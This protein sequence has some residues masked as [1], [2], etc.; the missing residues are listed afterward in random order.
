VVAAATTADDAGRLDAI[1]AE[2]RRRMMLTGVLQGSEE[3]RAEEMARCA[4]DP[5]YWM[6]NWAWTYDP[7][8]MDPWPRSLPFVLWPK[9]EELIR[10]LRARMQGKEQGGIKKARDTGVSWCCVAFGVWLWLFEPETTITYGS[11]K[12]GLVDKLG[13]PDSLVERARMILRM[14]PA[15]MLPTGYK[16]SVHALHMRL[17]N[18]ANSSII[19]GEV[20]DDM[21]RGGR[22]SIY[23][24]DEFAYVPRAQ[25][26][27]SA[28]SDNA[29]TVIWLSTSAGTGTEFWRKEQAG[30]IEFFR[31]FWHHDPRKDEAWAD[32]KKEVDGPATFAREHEGDDASALDNV[33]IPYAWLICAIDLDL[34]P[35]R[36]CAG[37]LDVADEGADENVLM[38]RRGPLVT[39]TETWTGLLPNQSAR[40]AIQTLEDED[41]DWLHYDRVGVGSGVAGELEEAPR[42]FA[43]A[44]VLGGGKPS[45]T[46]YWD[47]PER[48]AQERFVDRNAELWWHLRLRFQATYEQVEGIREHPPERLI[49]IPNDARLI[50]QLTSRLYTSDGDRKIA[51]ESKRAMRK[52]G[53][54]KSPDRADACAYCFAPAPAAAMID[55]VMY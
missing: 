49:S 1:S 45:L 11:R 41:A 47:D 31:I 28:I 29:N 42:P 20:G 27:S 7:R 2:M 50:A 37:G 55:E 5:V 13:D 38:I 3:A 19:K 14:L 39:L 16:E 26:V 52:R 25:A 17:L 18:P 43:Y 15:W 48:S 30:A 32:K 6:A 21:G 8:K 22:S 10:W 46:Y 36:D 33:T 51:V 54:G 9:Q 35:G 23:F 53:V 24:A 34:D 40:R 4:A 12:A 44:G